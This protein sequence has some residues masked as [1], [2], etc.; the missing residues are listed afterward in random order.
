VSANGRFNVSF[1]LL[2]AGNIAALR[3]LAVAARQEFG[4]IGSVMHY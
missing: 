1:A 2:R 4:A 3:G